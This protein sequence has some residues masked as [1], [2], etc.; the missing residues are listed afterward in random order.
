LEGKEE[1]KEGK[2]GGRKKKLFH[3]PFRNG[4]SGKREGGKGEE[5]GEKSGVSLSVAEIRVQASLF[6]ALARE[7]GKK[8]REEAKR[9][10]S[11]P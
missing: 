4:E 5:K 1:K 2:E 9:G 6:I 11:P 3:A 8:E 7:R 10:A